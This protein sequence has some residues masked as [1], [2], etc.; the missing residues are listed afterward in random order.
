[1]TQTS[2]VKNIYFNSANQE[3]AW[4]KIIL[5]DTTWFYFHFAMKYYY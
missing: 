3:I 4:S 1:M 5:T 2:I